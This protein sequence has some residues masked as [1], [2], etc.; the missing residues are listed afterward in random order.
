VG[1]HP[2]IGAGIQISF[3]KGISS[4]L[5][6]KKS[7]AS[8]MVHSTEGSN[9]HLGIFARNIIFQTQANSM[10][11]DQQ[12]SAADAGDHFDKRHQPKT[13]IHNA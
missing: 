12:Q 11:I 9:V 10:I 13:H 1:T 3:L 6:D 4:L 7:L 2:I 5:C 8:H